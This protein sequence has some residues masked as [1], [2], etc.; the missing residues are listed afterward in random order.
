MH[1]QVMTVI[2][3]VEAWILSILGWGW[4]S[5]QEMASY[6]FLSAHVFYCLLG[7]STLNLVLTGIS[8]ASN[9]PRSAY[10]GAVLILFLHTAC[11]VGDT[12]YTPQMGSVVFESPTKDPACTLARSQQLFFFSSSQFFAVQAGITLGYLIVQLIVAGAGMIDGPD[13]TLWPGVAWITGLTMMVCC[14]FFVMFDGSAKGVADQRTRYVQL[15]ALP[16][17]EIATV[18]AGF[19]YFLGCLLGM[20]GVVFPGIAWRKSV[21]YVTF[22]F[23]MLGV[24][25]CMYILFARGFLTPSLLVLLFV[26][27]AGNIASLVSAIMA[28]AEPESAKPQAQTASN[29]APPVFARYPIRNQ[30]NLPSAPPAQVI[31]G[32]AA[33]NPA[34][35]YPAPA[36]RGGFGVAVV[37]D[38]LHSGAASR[39]RVFIPAPVEMMGLATEKKK[40]V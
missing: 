23:S 9:G 24:G 16:V 17:V 20:E 10:F 38:Q 32:P 21:R 27:V 18:F 34:N 8:P 37:G 13:Q 36:N 40:G 6:S 25:F 35:Y 3:A 22:V 39:S 15:F 30:D 5:V 28:A 19:M 7:A 26:I 11:C 1:S 12:L 4:L 29:Q 2:Y 31:F 33:G 14:R